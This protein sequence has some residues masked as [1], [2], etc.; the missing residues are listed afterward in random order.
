[1]YRC[2]GVKFFFYIAIT[3]LEGLLP[4]LSRSLTV[5]DHPHP[6]L[7]SFPSFPDLCLLYRT[8]AGG[9]F[10]LASCRWVY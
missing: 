7:L 9:A 3:S 8:I 6:Q 5:P 10:L 2:T 4:L 1:M